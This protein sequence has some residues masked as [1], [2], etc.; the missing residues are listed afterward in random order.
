LSDGKPSKQVVSGSSVRR[1]TLFYVAAIQWGFAL[2]T[3]TGLVVRRLLPPEVFGAYFLAMTVS[4]YLAVVNTPLGTLVDVQVPLTLGRGKSKEATG[5]V[6]EIYAL[7]I[8]LLLAEGLVL[9]AIGWFW[10]SGTLTRLAFALVALM[11]LFNGI[12]SVDRLLLKGYRLFRILLLASIVSGILYALVVLALTVIWGAKGFL[13]GVTL[14]SAFQFALF[15][16][17]ATREFQL[18]WSIQPTFQHIGRPLLE[19]GVV[20]GLYRLTLFGMETIDRLYIGSIMGLEALGIYSLAVA[21][22]GLVGMVPQA[23]ASGAL[24][25]FLMVRGGS[26]RDIVADATLRFHQAMIW[27]TATLALASIVAAEFLVQWLFPAYVSAVRPA[28]VLFLAEVILQA[29]AAPVAF[30][31]G[32]D[33]QRPLLVASSV[34]LMVAGTVGYFL[35]HAGGLTGIAFA[36]LAGY[37]VSYLVLV[38]AIEPRLRRALVKHTVVAS[39]LVAGAVGLYWSPG[40]WWAGVYAVC[41]GAVCGFLFTR[42]AGLAPVLRSFITGKSKGALS[43]QNSDCAGDP[44][45]T[46]KKEV[47]R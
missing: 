21:L 15:R 19:M 7:L 22:T 28:Q 39:A 2:S 3:L 31:F 27:A 33:S 13:V 46:F 16:I 8:W 44:L 42:A 41:M 45:E 1:D 43:D 34:G 14:A 25:A 40:F 29:R 37:G 4:G 32:E 47:S 9:L 26:T 20:I 24:S 23:M 38:R 10:T 12:F 6:R 30:V 17:I 18:G 35:I 11:L 5:L 36:T